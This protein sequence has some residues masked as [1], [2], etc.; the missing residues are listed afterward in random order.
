MNKKNSRKKVSKKKGNRKRTTFRKRINK[1][2]GSSFQSYH[3]DVDRLRKVIKPH[4]REN[5][6]KIVKAMKIAEMFDSG[7]ERFL[8]EVKSIGYIYDKDKVSFRS[9]ITMETFFILVVCYNITKDKINKKD[10]SQAR[11]PLIFNF[12]QFHDNTYTFY[13]FTLDKQGY[14]KKAKK[15]TQ[16]TQ[17]PSDEDF[18]FSINMDDDEVKFPRFQFV[19]AP[20]Y[21]NNPTIE[22]I[23]KQKGFE[24]QKMLN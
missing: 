24:T 21:Q 16:Y 13:I 17:S 22:G 19:K 15:Y 2:G 6:F 23:L 1:T 12:L 7:T 4:F 3:S 9:A 10:K 18:R 14:L 5:K 20:R 8:D 11:I